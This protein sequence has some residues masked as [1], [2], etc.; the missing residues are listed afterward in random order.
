MKYKNMKELSQA[1][2]EQN[3]H[4]KSIKILERLRDIAIEEHDDVTAAALNQNI[5]EL[6]RLIRDSK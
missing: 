4:I 1:I 5:L 6:K 2:D 3:V